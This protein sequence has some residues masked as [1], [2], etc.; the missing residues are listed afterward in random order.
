MDK[1][2]YSMDEAAHITGICKTKLYEEVNEGRLEMVKCGR[3]SIITAGNSSA[4]SRR[5]RS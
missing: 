3:R 1:L 5:S 2:T 4:G